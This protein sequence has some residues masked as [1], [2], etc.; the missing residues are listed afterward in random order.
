[1]TPPSGLEIQL[2]T[3]GSPP[4][5][6]AKMGWERNSVFLLT[7]GA[8][9]HAVQ[10]SSTGHGRGQT[11]MTTKRDDHGN[12][13]Y[14]ERGL[15]P[16][17]PPGRGDVPPAIA[18]QFSE[19]VEHLRAGR[20]AE[21]ERLCR[22]MRAAA[23]NDAASVHLSGLVA[24]QLGR[25]DALSL[26]ERAIA[27]KPDSA[28]MHNDLG[29]MLAAY[30]RLAEAVTSF[31]RAIDINPV[32][33]EARSN[34]GMALARQGRYAD[35]NATFEAALALDP[36]AVMAHLH[37]GNVLRAQRRL[38]DAAE[39]Y[40][41]AVTLDPKLA[42]AHYSLAVTAKDLGRLLEA[43][44]HF[45]H[46]LALD[47]RS[48]EGHNNLATVL[49]ELG[50]IEEAAAHCREALA[51]RPNFAAAHNN[52]ANALR[53]LGVL[54]EAA[55]HYEW[56]CTL[57]PGLAQAHYNRGLI[58]RQKSRIDQAAACFEHAVAAAPD[59]I[60]A[61][62]AL[63]MAQLPIIY[64]DEAEIER[65]RALYR[66]HLLALDDVVAQVALP[67]ALAD[68]VGGD[69]PFR[70]AAQG[71]CDRDL[72]ATY[73]AMACRIMAGRY[74]RTALAK[75]PPPGEPLRVGFVSG[76]FRQHSSWKIPTKGWLTGLDRRRFR[77]FGYHTGADR[78]AETDV[79]AASCERF[80]QGPL[81]ADGWRAA[82]QQDAPHVLIYPEI[83][84]DPMCAKLAAQRLAPVQCVSFGH[85][86]T[87]G[88]PTID[89]YLSGDLMEPPGGAGHYTETLVRL[90]NLSIHYEPAAPAPVALSRS[91][92]DMRPDAVAF[93]C[94]HAVYK[95]LPQFDQVFPRI[96]RG[97]GDCQFVFIAYPGA[98]HVT[99]DLQDRLDDAFADFGLDAADH[100][101]ML[102]RLDAAQFAA[103]MGL[104]DVMLDSIGWSGCNTTFE[105]L[106]HDLPVVTLP[107][108]L[109]RGRH[110]AAVLR[111]MDVTDTI[112]ATLDDYIALAVRLVREP[113]LRAALKAK[114]AANKQRVYG[115]MACIMGLEDFLD[116]AA[117][118]KA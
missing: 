16:W 99:A 43:V 82:I 24:Y 107:G 8:D 48:A 9:Y 35:A 88:F 1:M 10:P 72:Q 80:V 23:P 14:R 63:C 36:K 84:I 118:Q 57:A 103:A 59:F 81:P 38:D 19:A 47:P 58:C 52:L 41:R 94:G 77:V 30:A 66:S 102:P 55:V 22:Q 92:V 108:D 15:G 79:A 49:H 5:G 44:T 42:V 62:F 50:R 20:L 87:S 45:R 83:G 34:L 6:D 46:A 95:H 89:Y 68:A 114:I 71:H 39:H 60:P 91:D 67:G 13:E 115:D 7:T 11:A 106:A 90:P 65:R 70:L 75:P 12:Q 74:P 100:C 85:P 105:A 109:M 96:V 117:R 27:L 54:D 33:I 26:V 18:G 32:H 61:R 31:K 4:P 25:D 76:F 116:R 73:G 53:D 2:I 17:V 112:A 110:S 78:D 28:D 51:L 37:F 40:R 56:A 64:H 101:V 21:A 3:A 97:A 29:A 98:P 86:D 111:M 69:Q 104:A 93:W 113:D